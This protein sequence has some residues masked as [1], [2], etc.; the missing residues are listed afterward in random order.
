MMENRAV[1]VRI[2]ELW[3][4]SE[5][6]KKQFMKTLLRNIRAALDGAGISYEIEEFRG[7]VI[8]Y[9]DADKIAA[10]VPRAEVHIRPQ[11]YL[12]AVFFGK[13]HCHKYRPRR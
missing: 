4:K 12:I 9:G 7:R 8:I 10:V 2:G 1:M 13:C 11:H 3:L 6:V 5:P